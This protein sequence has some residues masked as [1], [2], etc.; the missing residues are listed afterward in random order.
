MDRRII[1]TEIKY[2]YT[3]VFENHNN[4]FVKIPLA[5]DSSGQVKINCDDKVLSCHLTDDLDTKYTGVCVAAD[6]KWYQFKE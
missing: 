1:S 2:K 6:D 4:E 5:N 3:L